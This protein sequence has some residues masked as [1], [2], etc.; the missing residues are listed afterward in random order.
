MTK[1]V[2]ESNLT[3]VAGVAIEITFARTNLV[4]L[5]WEGKNESAFD[6]LQRY[7]KGILFDYE[8][9]E[10]CDASVCCLSLDK[11]KRHPVIRTKMDFAYEHCFTCKECRYDLGKRTHYCP[12]GI[13]KNPHTMVCDNWKK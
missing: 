2:L 4:T 7:F 12:N 11:P 9:D 10:E 5:F 13:I 8:Y 6:K 1:Q 3:K